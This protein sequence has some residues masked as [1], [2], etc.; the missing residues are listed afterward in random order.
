MRRVTLIA[1]SG[2]L[3][4]LVAAAVRQRGDTLEVIDIVGRGDLDGATHLTLAQASRLFNLD[5]A[6]CAE[7]LGALVSDGRL[8]TDGKTFLHVSGGRHSV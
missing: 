6:R 2:L 3:A 1:G 8:R 7:A 5:P 4:P